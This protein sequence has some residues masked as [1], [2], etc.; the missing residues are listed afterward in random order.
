MMTVPEL[1]G[2]FLGLSRLQLQLW[3]ASSPFGF[4]LGLAALRLAAAFGGFQRHAL[5]LAPRLGV[6]FLLR[7][8]DLHRAAGLLDRRDGGLRRPI[9][10]EI[11]LALEFAAAEQL[12]AA[13]G[14]PHQP[15]LDHGRDVDRVF[16]V[17]QAGIDRRLHLA[18]I[19]LV[20]LDRERGV[21]EAALG[22]APMQR[23]LAAFEA[24]D[25]H[26]R[27]RG[28]ALAAAAAGLAHAGADATADAHAVLAARPDCRRSGS[29]SWQSS[30]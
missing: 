13:L 1:L 25:A 21:A 17:D 4:R 20:E 16:G 29:V 6:H 10:R 28:L 22:Q 14:A 7:R 9:D 15:G 19:G 5:V 8:Q 2:L 23:H 11:D 30:S 26:A 18:E 27:A 12:H 24:L 3:L